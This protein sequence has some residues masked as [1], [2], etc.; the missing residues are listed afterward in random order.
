MRRVA[1]A[2]G[3]GA[4]LTAVGGAAAR[5]PLVPIRPG[6]L[7]VAPGGG[8]Y[9]ADDA[10]DRILERRPDGRFVAVAGT[11]ARGFSGDGGPAVRARLNGPTGMVIAADG[12]LYFADAGNNR[13]RAVS[14][15]GVVRTVAGNGRAGWT[16]D[17]ANALAA[18][19]LSPEAVALDPAGRL[20]IAA[21]GSGEVLRLEQDGTL[22]R[23][24]GIRAAAGLDGV[25]GPAKAASSDGADA[26]AYDGR[27]D[28]FL[29]GLNTKTL[30]QVDRRGTLRLPAGTTGFYP[31]GPGGLVAAPGGRVLAV[32]TQAVVEVTPRGLRTVYSFA[33]RR[34]GRVTGFLPQG[35]AVSAAGVMYTDT[36]R[37][38]GWAS[39]S[40]IVALAPGP[41]PR[42][43]WSG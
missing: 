4:F 30:L 31:R 40:A 24:V 10:Q 9:V 25:D 34:V 38:N 43:L 8:L 21:S 19:L 27:G 2:V 22:T 16:P 13:I 20:V 18:P 28:L 41:R 36:S 26:L 29:A 15:R 42:V 32:D 35:L 1:I 5:G 7:A 6:A 17:G 33:G 37:G 23:L 12:T 14:R 3:V 39:G 11:G